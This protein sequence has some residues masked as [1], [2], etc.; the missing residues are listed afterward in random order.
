VSLETDLL[1]DRRR[2]KRRLFFWR[3]LAIAAVLACIAAVIR[4]RLPHD[5]VARLA[6]SGVITDTSRQIAALDAMA[7]DA[8][9]KALIVEIDSPGGGVHASAALRDAIARVA[10]TKPVVAVMGAT[11]ASGGLM[12]AMGAPHV[13]AA[14]TTLTG[15]IGVILETM[16]VSG[17]LARVGV[18]AEAITSGPLKDQPSFTHP[19]SDAGR[20]ELHGVVGDMFDQFVTL[21]ATARHMDKGKVLALADGRVFTGRQAL[22]AGLVD[23]LGDDATARR[24]LASHSGIPQALP[25]R[26]L[27]TVSQTESVLAAVLTPLRDSLKTVL[28]QGLVVDAGQ[29]LWQPA[30]GQ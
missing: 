1:I 18:T 10:A 12:V 4:P 5:H 23:E 15:S 13:I 29:A 11:A 17:L 9:A 28:Y 16:E 22:A 2:L 19:L 8:S 25:L 20:A 26:P 14:P 21:V 30:T 7:R 3:V 27:R 24:W 6:V